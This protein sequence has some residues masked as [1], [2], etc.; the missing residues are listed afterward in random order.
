MVRPAV[1]G[2]PDRVLDDRG[3]AATSLYPPSPG[4]GGQ[5]TV[6]A[7]IGE[8]TNRG[9]E[10]EFTALPTEGLTLFGSLGFID[11]NQKGFCTDGDGF[12]GTDPLNPPG[13]PFD[14]LEQC[15]PAEQVLDPTGNF[16]GWLVP[17]DNSNL[18]PSARTPK[19]TLNLGLAYEVPV[20]NAGFV[21][22]AADWSYNSKLLVSVSNAGELDGV[23]QFNGDFLDH[24]R[25]SSNIINA[26]VTWRDVED[27]YQVAFFVKNLTNELYK[28]A[29]TNVAGLFEF[30]V[31][32]Q[33]RHWGIEVNFRL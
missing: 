13:P 14:F 11:T 9:I 17:T 15:G 33:R 29:V 16:I 24:F 5:E 30:R 31:P 28:Q 4:A 20:G 26:S 12:S 19:W 21:T 2:Q 7:N 32:N 6:I 22:F 8:V 18:N 10:L 27:R 23:T 1:A 25:K 3:R